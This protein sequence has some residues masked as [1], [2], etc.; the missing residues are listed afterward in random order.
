PEPFDEYGIS[1]PEG[2][3]QSCW[4]ECHAFRCTKSTSDCRDQCT[5][6]EG[7]HSKPSPLVG[8]LMEV[9]GGGC[10]LAEPRLGHDL[11]HQRF[12]MPTDADQSPGPQCLIQDHP[13]P[14]EDADEMLH[15]RW[16]SR[17]R[18][19]RCARRPWL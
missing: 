16:Q 18:T 12:G 17:L 13:S 3:R 11:L 19:R 7:G 4:K 8:S 5:R 14:L 9:F 1:V 2:L 10:L 15:Q 6:G